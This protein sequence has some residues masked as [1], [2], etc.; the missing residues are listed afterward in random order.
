MARTSS[1]FP[2]ILKLDANG[3]RFGMNRCCLRSR[4]VQ[5][6]AGPF[7]LVGGAMENQE[8]FVV[9]H[10]G[11]VLQDAVLRNPDAV[12]ARAEGVSP[13]KRAASSSAPTI[14]ITSGPAT[15]N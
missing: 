13:A 11:L 6:V 5:E 14:H 1:R 8:E 9:L 4:L 3:G 15:S 2:T 10:L 12:Q 7:H